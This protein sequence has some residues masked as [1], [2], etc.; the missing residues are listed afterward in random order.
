MQYM[1]TSIDNAIIQSRYGTQIGASLAALG[2]KI[3]VNH[4]PPVPGIVSWTRS[5]QRSLVERDGK[6]M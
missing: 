2:V 3:A 1:S 5:V 6:V 4:S